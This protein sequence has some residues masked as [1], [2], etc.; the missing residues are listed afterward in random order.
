MNDTRATCDL[1]QRTYIDPIY[2]FVSEAN[3]I[4]K[5]SHEIDMCDPC[6]GA[7]EARMGKENRLSFL[8]RQLT[9]E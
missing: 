8:M 9:G 7:I 5:D 4:L 1:C 2:V 3:T 6:L